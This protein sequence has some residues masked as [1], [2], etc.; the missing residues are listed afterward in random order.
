MNS[1]KKY[2][3]RKSI[4]FP[5]QGDFERLK[6]LARDNRRSI[7]NYLINLIRSQ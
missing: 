5:V 6:K 7:S 1:K 2:N 4:Y 3:P